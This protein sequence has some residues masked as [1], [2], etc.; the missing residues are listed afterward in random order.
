MKTAFDL[1]HFLPYQLSAAAGRVSRAFAEHYRDEFGITIPEWRVLA[2][3][4]QAEDVSV[5]EIHLKVDMDKSKVSRA[6][7]KLEA[8]GY[9]AKRVNS[10]DKRLVALSLTPKGE[11]LVGRILPVALAYQT[12]LEERLAGLSPALRQ[13]LDRLR[14]E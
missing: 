11:A 14:Q 5:R 12:E 6:A 2:H 8:A 3:L 9:I 4:T 7:S 1:D 10:D 13:A